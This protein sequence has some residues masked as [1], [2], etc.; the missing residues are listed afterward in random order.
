MESIPLARIHPMVSSQLPQKKCMLSSFSAPARSMSPAE[1]G[2]SHSLEQDQRPFLRAPARIGRQEPAI[3]F[4]R[5]Y[6]AP[7]HR[8][9]TADSRVTFPAPG[10]TLPN[11]SRVPS[12]RR[13]ARRWAINRSW[14]K[15]RQA[16][17]QVSF[18][19]CDG[20]SIRV[21]A[22]AFSE[23]HSSGLPPE[24]LHS[25]SKTTSRR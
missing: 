7:L 23:V 4:S 2:V 25:V 17:Y 3:R 6:R 16:R 1:P 13:S 5:L 18:R 9:G 15:G 12:S 11:E 8:T 19:E 24:S 10:S 22:L 20:A 14:R 21:G